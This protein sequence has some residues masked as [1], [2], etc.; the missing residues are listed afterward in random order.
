MT[1]DHTSDIPLHRTHIIYLPPF[2]PFYIFQLSAC[3]LTLI[4]RFITSCCR[5]LQQYSAAVLKG[6]LK[7]HK[8]RL[9]SIE[10]VRKGLHQTN[11]QSTLGSSAFIRNELSGLRGCFHTAVSCLFLCSC[12][13]GQPM[14]PNNASG[15]IGLTS[16][17]C[18][19]PPDETILA[20][21]NKS[22]RRCRR[23]GLP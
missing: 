18:F 4:C 6:H 8:K 12:V 3:Q 14:F 17:S 20:S 21:R 13:F 7:G 22:T 2:C 16:S 19:R 1:H 11:L 9:S 10:T 5:S 15:R 23:G